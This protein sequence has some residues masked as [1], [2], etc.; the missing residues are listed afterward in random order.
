MEWGSVRS[1][2]RA[3]VIRYPSGASPA[4]IGGH[5]ALKQWLEQ[6]H[7]AFSEGARRY[8]LPLPRGVLLVGPQG[9]GKSLTAKAIAHGWAMPLLRLD[10]GRLTFLFVSVAGFIALRHGEDS[11]SPGFS[12]RA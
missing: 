8:G 7:Q 11:L 3:L 6:R 4:D 12:L 5:G 10:V 1:A 2:G 9:T